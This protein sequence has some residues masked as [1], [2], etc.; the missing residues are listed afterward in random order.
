[1]GRGSQPC[2][3]ALEPRKPEVAQA[4]LGPFGRADEAVEG[5]GWGLGRK[6]TLFV[7]NVVEGVTLWN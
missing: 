6:E 1:M 5:M 7:D 2:G 3:V 4:A